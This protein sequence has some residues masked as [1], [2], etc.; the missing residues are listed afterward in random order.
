VA[1]NIF[2]V[3]EDNVSVAW[4]K[5]IEHLLNCGGECFNL[6]VSIKNPIQTEPMIHAAY[7]QLLSN[8]GLLSLKQVKYTI[9]PQSL[10]RQVNRDPDRLFE[11]YNR[12]GGVYYRLRRRYPRKFGWG[13]Y[14]RRMTYY[15]VPDEYG[16]IT[17]VN[18]LGEIIQ[19]IRDRT[20]TY[21]AAYTI[22]IQIP[23]VDGRRI[24]GGPCLNYVALQLNTPR[25]LN[26]LAVYRNHDFIQRAYGNY[27]GLG[28]VMEFI[29]DQTGYSMGRLNCL[30]SHASIA[31]LAGADSW[32]S[33]AE[34]RLISQSMA[35]P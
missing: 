33:V 7:E 16:N 9:F 26:A 29:C 15:P 27:L 6:M 1:T 10:Y 11:R 12:I 4:L 3:E 5:A 14:F 20:R 31:N 25:V 19:M 21:K 24:I 34:I 22:S 13:S 32:P 30:S 8:H 17:L 18:Q 35:Q 28:Y 2:T 23:G